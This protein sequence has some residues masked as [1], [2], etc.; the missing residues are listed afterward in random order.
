M[1]LRTQQEIIEY[2]YQES[3][4]L[5]SSQHLIIE[6]GLSMK[7]KKYLIC[8]SEQLLHSSA[9]V[10]AIISYLNSVSVDYSL[11]SASFPKSNYFTAAISYCRRHG[12]TDIIF[13]TLEQVNHPLL[14]LHSLRSIFHSRNHIGVYGFYFKYSNITEFSLKAIMIKTAFLLFPYKKIIISSPYRLNSFQSYPIAHKIE[15]A[16]DFFLDSESAIHYDCHTLED[17]YLVRTYNIKP[18][19]FTLAYV[20]LLSEKKALS[21]LVN[22]LYL[23]QKEYL[24]ADVCVI[25][26]GIVHPKV[27]K[28]TIQRIES[29]VKQNL[30]KYIPRFLDHREFY[31]TLSSADAS[32]CVQSNFSN[33]SGVFTRSIAWG[34]IPIVYEQTTIGKLCINKGIGSCL[35]SLTET[36][37]QQ[38][39][40]ALATS[41]HKS[42]FCR[43]IQVAKSY[44]ELHCSQRAFFSAL[45][46]I[47]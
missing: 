7:S 20:G 1:A 12:C 46:S 2:H 29:L 40:V 43:S 6:Q 15:Y 31:K 19:S 8:G 25:L 14:F 27:P 13:V 11:L 36:S 5:N 9:Y 4:A 33:S 26:A 17:N 39:I 41:R 21:K 30:I 42:G 35:S 24:K 32:W 3:F 34:T 45:S 47:L 28:E 18:S 37:I 16:P 22:S 23:H 38:S 44:A 10:S